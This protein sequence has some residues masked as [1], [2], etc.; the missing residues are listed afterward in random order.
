[1]GYYEA[2]AEATAAYAYERASEM[3]SERAF[4]AELSE[5]ILQGDFD[6]LIE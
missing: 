5:F 1:M 3:M 4:S 6:D 2:R